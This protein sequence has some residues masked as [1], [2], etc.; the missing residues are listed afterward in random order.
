MSDAHSGRHVRRFKWIA[1]ATVVGLS[2]ALAGGDGAV[3][4]PHSTLSIKYYTVTGPDDRSLDQQ[5]ER[6]GPMH[7]GGKAYATLSADPTFDGRLVGGKSC[8]LERFRVNAK[9]VMT[10]PKLAPGEKLSRA[11][12]ARWKRFSTFVRRHEDRHR[13]IWLGCLARGEARAL[14]LRVSDCSRLD[15]A[16]EKIFRQEW[17]RCETLHDAWDAKQRIA[18]KSQ[19]LIVAA[20]KFSRRA[21]LAKVAVK[22][23]FKT[24]FRGGR[25]AQ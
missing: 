20:G 13:A 22:T 7:R 25:A 12:A 19:P 3:A 9:F 15:A 1:L 4:R 2:T 17:V 16:V 21:G 24:A 10:L 23:S 5:M 18:L 8:R 11:T 6:F 14:K